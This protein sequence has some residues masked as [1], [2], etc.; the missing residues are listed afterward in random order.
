MNKYV[1]RFWVDVEI[2]ADNDEDMRKIADRCP[3]IVDG[4]MN[5]DECG[6][7]EIQFERILTKN[8]EYVSK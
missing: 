1:V 2:S 7:Y 4:S 5:G 3:I 6:E 8:G